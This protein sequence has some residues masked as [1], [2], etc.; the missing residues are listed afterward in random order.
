MYH[1]SILDS[2]LY[3]F[4]MQE[5]ICQLYPRCYSRYRF[6][7]RDNREFPDGF[8]NRLREI[9]NSFRSIS[10]TSEEKDFLR[11]KCYY[12]NPVYLDFLAGYRY[13]PEEV[14]IVQ[15]GPGGLSVISDVYKT[16]VYKLARLYPEIPENSI[17]KPPSAELKPDQKDTDSLPPY[18]VLDGILK[19]YIERKKS[20]S[21]ILDKGFDFDVTK[22][23]IQMVD[24]N[25]YKRHQAAPGLIIS[26]RDLLIGRRMP[27]ANGFVQFKNL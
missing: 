17:V 3:K 27:I 8:A 23:V 20:F 19:Q 6:I 15:N 12:L 16:T 26:E 14:S 4:T 18:D 7:N 21:E 9:L 5:A 22:R 25:E 24:R 1:T 13:N 11:E 10:L 2:D